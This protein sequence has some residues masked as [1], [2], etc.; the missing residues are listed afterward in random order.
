MNLANYARFPDKFCLLIDRAQQQ[1]FWRWCHGFAKLKVTVECLCEAQ[2]PNAINESL[3][4][5]SIT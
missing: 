3:E 5:F 2:Q 4:M 1:N